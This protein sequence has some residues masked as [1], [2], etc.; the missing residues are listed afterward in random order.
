MFKARRNILAAAAILAAVF[1]ASPFHVSAADAPKEPALIAVLTSNAPPGE[2]A[3]TCK[4][5]AIYGSKE[6]VPA[7]APLLLDKELTSWARIALEAIPDAAAGDA[8]RDAMG[9]AQGRILIGIINSISVRHDAKAVDGLIVKLKDADGDIVAAA[10]AALGQIGGDTAAAALE[11][12]LASVPAAQKSAVAQ[13]CVICASHYLADGKNDQ[14]LKLYETV[15]KAPVSRQRVLEATRGV[16]LAR[17]AAGIPILAEQLQSPDKAFF[18]LGLRVSREVKDAAVT[19]VLLT[20]MAKTGSERQSLL[21]LALADRADAK[22]LPA[23]IEALKTKTGPTNVRVV[24]AGAIERIGN[25]SCVPVLLDAAA[26]DDAEVSKAA[27][28]TLARLIGKDI[29]ADLLARLQKS[30]GKQRQILIE[31]AEQRRID[32]A[33]AL[34]LVSAE[35]ADAEVRTASLVAIGAIGEDKQA[36]ELLKLLAK[37][38]D[39][40]DRDQIEKA[41]NS[42]CARYGAACLPLVQPLLKSDDA[43]NRTVAIHAIGA[44]GGADALAAIATAANDKDAAVGDE[45][46]RTLSTWPNRWPE[47]AGVVEPLLSLA[48]SARKDQHKI[49]AI[50]GYLQYVHGTKKL[51]G[52]GKLAKIGDILPLITRPEEKRLTIPVYKEIANAGAIDALAGFTADPA[53]SEEASSAIFDLTGKASRLTR[54]QKQKGL[55]AVAANSKNAA[56]KKKAEDL[57][58][59]LK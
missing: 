17:Q 59:G 54:E 14:A 12:A 19:D 6:A 34:F 33:M 42:I 57:L 49:L 4:K 28:A 37:A 51:N 26:G 45:A 5:L 53:L 35:D 10:A 43:A 23:I 21:L 52:A 16:I 15:R 22:A 24:A 56:T 30:T 29:D 47:D 25:V 3:I 40:Q 20:E 13:G 18:A 27:K 2:K 41:L 44:C 48:K 36:P 7:L 31:L 11:Q 32:G 46:V 50:R 1:A 38:K 58:S 8:L 39:P 55:Q 9:K